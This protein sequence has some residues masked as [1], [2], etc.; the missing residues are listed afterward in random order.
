MKAIFLTLSIVL[1]TAKFLFSQHRDEVYIFKYSAVKV[2]R[3]DLVEK[4]KIT[5]PNQVVLG[6][7]GIKI[8]VISLDDNLVVFRPEPMSHPTE[9][10]NPKIHYMDNSDNDNYFCMEKERFN[11]ECTN[12]FKKR[13]DGFVDAI[14]LPFK[15]RFKNAQGGEFD[16]TQS[17][18]VGGAISFELG[19]S[20]ISRTYSDNSYSIIVG[21]NATNVTVDENTVPNVIT[22]KTTA[23]GI[24][25]IFG[26]NVVKGRVSL[27]ALMGLDIL[28]GEAGRRWVY[29][30]SPWVGLSIGT[31]IVSTVK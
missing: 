28:T 29:R 5:N 3:Y 4:R 12:Q 21:L 27:G 14:V 16:F 13:V 6:A 31:S 10:L 1:L 22:S 18:S 26:F 19:K 24:T 17:V 9:S 25:P 8:V 2:E 11:L 23:L 20:Y 15:F 30:K 7:K